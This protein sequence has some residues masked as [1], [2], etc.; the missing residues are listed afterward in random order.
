MLKRC[1]THRVSTAKRN[2]ENLPPEPARQSIQTYTKN[3]TT[4]NL[5]IFRKRIS[6]NEQQIPRQTRQTYENP[7][8]NRLTIALAIDDE[9]YWKKAYGEIT[10]A[11]FGGLKSKSAMMIQGFSYKELYLHQYFQ[12]LIASDTDIETIFAITALIGVNLRSLVIE[13]TMA[14]RLNDYIRLLFYMPNLE[15]L[16]IRLNGLDTSCHSFEGSIDLDC[17]QRLILCERRAKLLVD[18]SRFENLISMAFEYCNLEAPSLKILLNAF[19]NAA[20]LKKLSFW[21]NRIDNSGVKLLI[22]FFDAHPEIRLQEL[23][24]S[25]NELSNDSVSLLTPWI[26][27]PNCPLISLD[28]STNYINNQG[29]IKIACKILENSVSR[30]RTLDL[31]SNL[32]RDDLGEFLTIFVAKNSTLRKLILD[33]NDIYLGKVFVQALQIAFESNWVLKELSLKYNQI[34]NDILSMLKP[35]H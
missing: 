3:N 9:K 29:F 10:E 20:W 26:S 17:Q 34:D 15:H 25:D 21:H 11:K 5:D 27:K 19:Q 28:L 4:Q 22:K 6:I 18:N 12:Q 7:E 30:L 35:S 24:L 1:S 14:D 31:S 8:V 33:G 32:I 2:S 23:I 16:V 13:N